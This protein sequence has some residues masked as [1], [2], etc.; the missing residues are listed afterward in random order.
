MLWVTKEKNLGLRDPN[1]FVIFTFV[2]KPKSIHESQTIIE[3]QLG[4]DLQSVTK[5][6]ETHFNFMKTPKTMF[7][8]L[9]DTQN[10]PVLP[11]LSLEKLCKA[12]EAEQA[13]FQPTL[14]K[15]AG[16]ASLTIFVSDCRSP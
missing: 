14:N 15:G 5:I 8:L 12:L 4:W 13:N 10:S 6:I 7:D 16:G 11:A 3:Q 9:K 1:T 2:E